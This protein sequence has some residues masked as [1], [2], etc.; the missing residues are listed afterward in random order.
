MQTIFKIF[1]ALKKQYSDNEDFFEIAPLPLTKNH[2]I[3]ISQ[4]EQ[5]MFFI[6]CEDSNKVKAIDCNLEFISVQ[7]NRKCQLKNNK[8]KIEEGVYT[9][10]SLKTNSVDLQEYFLEVIYLIIIKL[11]DKPNLKDL[12][13]EVE[14]LINLFSKFSKPALKTIQ[15]LW[16]ELLVIEQ[17]SN[18]D[19]LIKAWHSSTKDKF[20]FNDGSD[21]IE[22][23][24]T[25]RSRR[26]HSFSIEQLNQNKN[27]NLIIVSVFT[28]ETGIGK[29]TF[30]LIELIEKKIK[31]RDSSFRLN[32]IIAETLGQDFEKS[33]EVFFDYQSAIDSL[34]FYDS[35]SVPKISYNNIPTEVTNVKFDCDLTDI[36]E[37]KFCKNKSPLHSLLF[38][39]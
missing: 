14:K 12:K 26:I 35:K 18:P 28:I 32:E 3:G 6:K 5:P 38:Q 25:S 11:S 30:G 17:S 24:S 4:L 13:S 7:F 27:S 37:L 15:G 23:K 29:N 34:K 33:F 39:K 19:Y 9:I 10:I 1:L 2:K 31:D 22:I 20:D 16:A 36:T 21:K 8:N